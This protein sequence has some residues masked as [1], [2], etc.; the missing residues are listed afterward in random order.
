MLP[1]VPGLS[2]ASAVD[3]G[4]WTRYVK[5]PSKS[6]PEGKQLTGR[7]LIDCLIS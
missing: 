2:R 3:T 1:Q 4:H 5:R 6:E 7:R